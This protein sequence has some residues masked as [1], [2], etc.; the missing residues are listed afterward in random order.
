MFFIRKCSYLSLFK[1]EP[2]VDGLLT[3]CFKYLPMG[4]FT[5]LHLA[6][7]VPFAMSYGMMAF[8]LCPMRTWAVPM[9]VYLYHKASHLRRNNLR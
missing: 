7:L 3:K 5:S 9:A 8:L 2:S 4:V 6:A 1:K